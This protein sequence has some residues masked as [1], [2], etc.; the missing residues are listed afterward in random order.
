MMKRDITRCSISIVGFC[1]ICTVVLA[2]VPMVD[3]ASRL[4]VCRLSFGHNSSDIR[5]L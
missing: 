2:F 3:L 1:V 5:I 4:R